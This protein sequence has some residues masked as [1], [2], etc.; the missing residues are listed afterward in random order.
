MSLK[1]K[2]NYTLITGA[3]SDLGVHICNLIGKN[4]NLLIH[5]RDILRLNKLK[6]KSKLIKK[7]LYGTKIF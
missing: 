5:G 1:I 2:N 6:K 7:L 4:N 3:T